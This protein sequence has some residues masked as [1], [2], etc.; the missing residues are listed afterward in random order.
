MSL[1]RKYY[2]FLILLL[3]ILLLISL[4]LEKASINTIRKVCLVFC[5]FI[6]FYYEKL[7]IYS[8]RLFIYNHNHHIYCDYYNFLIRFKELG[9]PNNYETYL[10]IK[11]DKELFIA[12]YKK[13][14]CL[15]KYKFFFKYYFWGSNN[16]EIRYS[17]IYDN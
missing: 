2:C 10:S 17:L 1:I 9:I 4:F 5:L 3:L 7:N 14:S 11:H 12:E 8:F 15:R 16:V 6:Y 13:W